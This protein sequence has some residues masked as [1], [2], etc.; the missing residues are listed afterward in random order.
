MYKRMMVALDGSPISMSALEQAMGLAKDQHAG[1]Q[2]VYVVEYPHVYIA[3]VGYDPV[4]VMEPL[5][6]EGKRVL[7]KVEVLMKALH[8]APSSRLI[9]NGY[10][11]KPQEVAK[12]SKTEARGT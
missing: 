8:L 10:A 1:L 3:D 12:A 11:G 7:E 4:A 2:A 5:V 9:D 6:T